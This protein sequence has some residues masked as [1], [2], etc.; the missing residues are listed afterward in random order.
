M[1]AMAPEKVTVTVQ[2]S[3]GEE[4]NL[5]VNDAMRQVLDFFDLLTLAGGEDGSAIAWHLIS[6][7]T[8][9]PFQVTA[10]AVAS[11]PGV[12]AEQIAR[13]E[14][15]LIAAG[16]NDIVSHA[17]IPDWMDKPARDKAKKLLGRNIEGIGI[18]SIK[19]GD[20]F[21]PIVLVERVA[22]S[23]VS[24]IDR[25]EKSLAER[26]D[27]LTRVEY[28]SLE[29]TIL[30]AATFRN[31]PAI[32]IKERLSEVEIHCVFS[33]ELA[34]RIGPKHSW[35]EAW[36]NSRVLLSGQIY[37]KKNGLVGHIFASDIEPVEPSPLRY[38][39]ISDPQFTSGL[40]VVD[41]LDL[42]EDEEVE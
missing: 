21:E 36:E 30:S 25:H 17:S 42:L 41:Y 3:V 31:H 24:V 35:S 34:K 15:S 37:Y 13:K 39:D 22:R 9:S 16:L 4:A 38:A 40:H 14:K 20:D 33:D 28:G 10:Q 18:T 7:T 23:A 2:S 8:N 6:A 1:T 5:T 27:D 29:A 19:L 32:R 11:K 26:V 12:I